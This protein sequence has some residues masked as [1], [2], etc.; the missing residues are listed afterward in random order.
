MAK[1]G[2]E[3]I[4][5]AKLDETASKSAATAKYTEGREIGPGANING[6]VNSSDVKDYG[7]DRTLLTDVSVTGDFNPRSHEGSDRKY[8]QFFSLIFMYIALKLI[9]IVTLSTYLFHFLLF[10]PSF[11][12]SFR[13]EPF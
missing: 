8:T 3:Y 1:I 7:D 2:F 11:S 5:A 6:T 9:I 12:S 10:P 13:C 4:A